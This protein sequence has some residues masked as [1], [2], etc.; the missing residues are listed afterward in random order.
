MLHKLGRMKMQLLLV[1]KQVKAHK[2]LVL[3]QS[4]S[5][6][7]YQMKVLPQLQLVY[8]QELLVRV[9]DEYYRQKLAPGTDDHVPPSPI[10]QYFQPL[11]HASP[12]FLTPRLDVVRSV[13]LPKSEVLDVFEHELP[14]LNRAVRA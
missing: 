7:V 1:Y 2:V 11:K 8:K 14:C 5:K 4:V 10:P 6:Q 12:A 13:L 3:L 9:A